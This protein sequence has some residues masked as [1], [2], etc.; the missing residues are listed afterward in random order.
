MP[1]VGQR[2]TTPAPGAVVLVVQRQCRR[3]FPLPG[4]VGTHFP[5]WVYHILQRDQGA[6]LVSLKTTGRWQTARNREF[7]GFSTGCTA[8]RCRFVSLLCFQASA[9]GPMIGI[10]VARSLLE[11]QA[12]Q[13]FHLDQTVASVDQHRACSGTRRCGNTWRDSGSPAPWR[14]RHGCVGSQSAN[15]G[16]RQSISSTGDYGCYA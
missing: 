12:V 5:H 10:I 14:S 2:G 4:T 3:P 9:L 11:Q 6:R 13:D 16:S 15:S 8:P 1:S 7:Q